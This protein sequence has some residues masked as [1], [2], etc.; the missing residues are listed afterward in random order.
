MLECESISDAMRDTITNA[1]PDKM[2]SRRGSQFAIGT[3][4]EQTEAEELRLLIEESFP[5]VK[6]SVVELEL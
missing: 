3:F 4:T 5:D 6:A 1:A 2:I